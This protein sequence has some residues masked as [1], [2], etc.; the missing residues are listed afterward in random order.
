M[1]AG[2]SA[3]GIAATLSSRRCSPTSQDD[4]QIAREEIFGP[5][6]SVIAFK[7]VEEVI[8]R[9]NRTNYGLAAGVWTWRHQEGARDREWRAGGHGLGELLPR[10]GCAGA[11][12]RV[13]AVR[14]RARAGRVWV[15]GVHRG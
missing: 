15:A 14:D 4:M 8:T 12:R 13:Q 3:P 5:V 10:A 11:I 9:A 1:P 2:A 6:M 7:D